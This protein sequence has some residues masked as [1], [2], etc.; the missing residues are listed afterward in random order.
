MFFLC[1]LILVVACHRESAR[2]DVA[3]EAWKADRS[4]ESA[5][6]E[7]DAGLKLNLNGVKVA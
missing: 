2:A 6:K 4:A 7:H 5:D 3:Y 1:K